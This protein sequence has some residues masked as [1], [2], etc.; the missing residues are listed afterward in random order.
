MRIQ[1]DMLSFAPQI[2]EHWQGYSFKVNFRG[3]ILKVTVGKDG[4]HFELQDGG[5][6]N[7]LVN[8]DQVAV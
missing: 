7:I 1:N 4:N 6:M 3:Q 2:P 5:T 8:G